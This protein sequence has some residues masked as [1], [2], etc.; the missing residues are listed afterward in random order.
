M[1]SQSRALRPSEIDVCLH[2]SRRRQDFGSEAQGTTRGK[3]LCPNRRR[4]TKKK[5][6]KKKKLQDDF[7][8]DSTPSLP[9]F[10]GT[11]LPQFA[12]LGG[13]DSGRV[14][15]EGE[16][17]GE[18]RHGWWSLEELGGGER[19]R[20]GGDGGGERVRSTKSELFSTADALF[21]SFPLSLLLVSFLLCF[22]PDQTKQRA[23][24]VRRLSAFSLL[25][26]RLPCCIVHDNASADHTS[27]VEKRKN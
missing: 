17:G 10:P 24:V 16:G 26:L 20:G 22:S 7:L 18:R 1:A 12:Y 13:G 27:P 21:F 23:M 3:E 9:R 5:K 15:A 11:V 25:F 6:K 2:V 8:F 19:G 4:R 14:A